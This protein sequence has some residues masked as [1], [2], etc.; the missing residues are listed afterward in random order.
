MLKGKEHNLFVKSPE[1]EA[2]LKVQPHITQ[3]L[4]R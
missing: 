1:K 3:V 4:V 2:V